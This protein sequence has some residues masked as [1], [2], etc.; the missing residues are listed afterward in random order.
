MT[1][2]TGSSGPDTVQGT[3]PDGL[4]VVTLS[5]SGELLGVHLQPGDYAPFDPPGLENCGDMVVA[6]WNDAQERLALTTPE[7]LH[8]V[9][10][11]PA[12]KEAGE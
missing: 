5:L 9:S 2:K 3:A 11:P 4:V 12:H 1:T 8:L 7:R 10:S 6:A